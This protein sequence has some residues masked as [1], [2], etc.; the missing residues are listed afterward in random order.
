MQRIKPKSRENRLTTTEIE[1]M[2]EACRH[3][4]E[5]VVVYGLLYTGMR[6]SEFIHMRRD[7]VDFKEGIIHIPYRQKCN[8]YECMAKEGEHRGFFKCKTK[9]GERPIPILEELRPI[10]KEYFGEYLSVQDLVE[11]R[12][13]A[14]RIVK[15]IA[16]RAKI[17][18]PVFPHCIRATFASLLVEKGLNDPITLKDVMGW[19]KINMAEA[20]IRLSGQAVK[21]KINQIWGSK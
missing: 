7:W 18:H 13:N 14:W 10:L 20:Y 21:E 3:L 15:N 1:T 17:E 8:C 9:H 6:I 2:K 5:R 16:R 4:E 12:V 19:K 11:N